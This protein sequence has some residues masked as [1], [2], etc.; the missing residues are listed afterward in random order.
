MYKRVIRE[1]FLSSI[2]VMMGYIVLGIAFGMLLENKGYGVVYALLMSVFIYAGSMQFVAIN[3]LTS[4]AS[5]ISAAIMTLLINARHM[6]YG[7]SMIKKFDDMGKFKLYMIFSL[8]DEKY[9][10]R[11]GTQ[12]PQDSKQRYYLFLI[13]FF[14]QCYWIIGSII[15]AFVGSLMTINTTGLDFAMTALFVV[16]VL[17]QFLTSERHIYTY[18]GFG[19][20]VICLLIFGS[21]SFIIPSMIGIILSLLFMYNKGG[22]KDA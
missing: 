9:S 15:G 6:V 12:V 3:L 16:I 21:E 22:M 11:V 13:S 5:L 1:A 10:L 8:T 4:G 17:E 7:L 2:P 14:D 20:S 19:V 18:I